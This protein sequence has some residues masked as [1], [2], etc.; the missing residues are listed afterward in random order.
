LTAAAL[1]RW[2]AAV[3]MISTLGTSA[4]S[5]DTVD[6]GSGRLSSGAGA[7]CEVE[8]TSVMLLLLHGDRP[9]PAVTPERNTR[10]WPVV[11]V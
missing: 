1:I 4:M 10:G 3:E 11:Q 6:N 8:S 7:E 5:R 9:G 2:S